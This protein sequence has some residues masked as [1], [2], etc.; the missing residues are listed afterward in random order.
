MRC[1]LVV[2]W[3]VL[4][5]AMTLPCV[6][7]S[8]D[9]V[10]LR[11]PGPKGHLEGTFRATGDESSPVVLIVPGS[12]PTDRDGN[13]PIGVR[14]NTY[15]Y[16]AADLA[17]RGIRSIRIDKR[18][19]FG[20]ES[21]I[22]NANDVALAD[23]ADD[24]HAWIEVVGSRTGAS[25][26]WLLGH[27]E[28]GLVSLLAAQDVPVGGSI[29]GLILAASPGRPFA[30][31]LRQQLRDNPANAS[32]L[33]DA[34]KAIDELASG[35]RVDVGGLHAALKHL[36]APAVQGFMMNLMSHDPA[37]LVSKTSVP[38][39]ILQGGRDLQVTRRD[40]RRL[41]DARPDAHLVELPLANHVLKAVDSTDRSAN[42]AT[43]SDPALPLAPGVIDA[44]IDFIASNKGG[45]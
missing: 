14:A 6:A 38:L 3:L 23:Y 16:L 34:M 19:M 31:I 25:C 36:F 39:L 5:L 12:G 44:I 2:S 1:R 37:V 13:S 40:A 35:R 24:L 18:G 7:E 4:S 42:L 10:N 33:D 20:S 21:A 27:S 11:A 43:Y 30:D 41:R 26:I 17:K 22:P 28:G 15:K 8:R 45:D 29:C 9:E 32:L